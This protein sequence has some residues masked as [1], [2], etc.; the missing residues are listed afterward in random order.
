MVM[1]KLLFVLGVAMLATLRETKFAYAIST[2]YACR[3]RRA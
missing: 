2:E 1:E 3:T